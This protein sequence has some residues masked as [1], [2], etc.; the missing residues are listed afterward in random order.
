MLLLS[1]HIK[2][3][4]RVLAILACRIVKIYVMFVCCVSAN[5]LICFTKVATILT[6]LELHAFEITC[7]NCLPVLLLCSS[8]EVEIVLQNRFMIHLKFE[9]T[10]YADG[11]LYSA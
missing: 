10:G 8:R 3:F 6:F 4:N 5:H 1:M 9:V 7:V 11:K 2:S